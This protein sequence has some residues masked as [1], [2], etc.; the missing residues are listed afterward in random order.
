MV[1]TEVKR[2]LEEVRHKM[3]RKPSPRGM[4][5]FGAGM[6]SERIVQTVVRYCC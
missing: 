4:G 2:I 3:G 6:A 1:G 5:I